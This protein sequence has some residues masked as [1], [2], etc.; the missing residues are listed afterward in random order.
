MEALSSAATPPAIGIA[1]SGESI[2]IAADGTSKIGVYK[3]VYQSD[4]HGYHLFNPCIC[5]MC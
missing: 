5:R 2:E 1:Q 3:L 4:S